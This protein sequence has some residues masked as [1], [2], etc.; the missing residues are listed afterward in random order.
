MN[1]LDVFLGAIVVMVLID[2]MFTWLMWRR[3]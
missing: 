3:S 2:G 1:P